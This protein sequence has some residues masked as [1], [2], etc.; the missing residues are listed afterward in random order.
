MDTPTPLMR[1]LNM[2]AIHSIM[3]APFYREDFRLLIEKGFAVRAQIKVSPLLDRYRITPEGI[4]EANR[5]ARHFQ[6]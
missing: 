6:R 2:L 1:A 3:D 4:K 5:N